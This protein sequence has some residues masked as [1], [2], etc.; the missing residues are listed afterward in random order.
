M[1]LQRQLDA[2]ARMTHGEPHRLATVAEAFEVQ[3]VVEAI[4]RSSRGAHVI[5]G[6]TLAVL[7]NE[8]VFGLGCGGLPTAYGQ[9]NRDVASTAATLEAA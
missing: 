7:A 6:R 9:T 2:V 4:L 8:P 3:T 1:V 5:L